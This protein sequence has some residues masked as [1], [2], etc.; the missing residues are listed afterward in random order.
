[1]IG[2]KAEKRQVAASIKPK[3]RPKSRFIKTTAQV[4]PCYLNISGLNDYVIT[5]RYRESSL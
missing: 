1:M 3:G 4:K 5:A 2:I